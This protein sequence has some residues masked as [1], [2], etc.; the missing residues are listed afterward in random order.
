LDIWSPRETQDLYACIEWAGTQ[1]W[2]NG[3]V[4]LNGISYYAMNQWWVAAL[5]PPHLAAMCV[6]EG[7][8]DYYRDVIRH[9]G[10]F[11]QFLTNL[12]PRAILRAQH[13]LGQRGFRS[14]VTGEWVSGPE[15]LSE[16]ELARNRVD[17]EA[18]MLAHPLDDA[19]TRARSAAWEEVATPFLSAANWGGQG[20]HPRGNFEGFLRAAAPR[21]WLEVHG[22]AHWEEFYTDYGAELQK[23]FFGYFLKGEDTGWDKEPPV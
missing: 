11:C 17:V 1:P 22:G 13:G 9:G 23:R 2:C 15:T 4:G 6:W 12:Y 20:L 7:A 16:D 14:P 18:W 8:A 10:I 21:K 19:E 3:K 5:H